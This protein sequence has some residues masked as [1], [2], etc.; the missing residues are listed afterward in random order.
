VN[1]PKASFADQAAATAANSSSKRTIWGYYVPNDFLKLREIS[2]TYTIPES[3]THKYL[4]ARGAS[5]NVA[6]RNLG[7]PWSKYPGIDPESNNS[8]ANTG[9]GNSELTA[10]PPLRYLITR[11]N[12]QF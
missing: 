7:Y 12:V 2:A 11:V 5:I 9:G 8:V 10:Q 4:R 6:A 1:D 3:V